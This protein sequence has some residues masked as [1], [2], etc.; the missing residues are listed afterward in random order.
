MKSSFFVVADRGNLKAFRVEKV[1]AERPPRLKLVREISFVDAHTR[2]VEMNT[3]LA[4]GFPAGGAPQNGKGGG[5]GRH[6]N[7]IAEKHYDIELDRRT[8]RQLAESIRQLVKEEKASAWSFAAPAALKNAILQELSAEEKKSL[9]E[10]VAGDFVN[11]TPGE[12]LGHF[13]HV[14]A[15]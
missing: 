4:G 12:L 9:S 3:D 1:P 10:A 15:A 7:S 14:R 6:Q 2:I 5:N 8:V 11:V 13:S